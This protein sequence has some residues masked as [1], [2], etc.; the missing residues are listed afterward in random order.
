MNRRRLLQLLSA[1]G[2]GIALSHQ[3]GLIGDALAA[4]PS[5]P[6]VKMR[7]GMA[8]YAG[9]TWPIVAVR[10]GWF[11]EVGIELDPP[12][13]RIYFEN[14]L[15]PLFQNKEMD[16]AIAYMGSLTPIIDRVKDIKPFMI[17]LWWRGN[18]IFTAPD[19]EFKTVDDFIEEG[20]PFNEAAMLTMA[21][22]KG[23][24]I[25]VPP[26]VSSRA[27]L[28]YVYGLGGMKLEDSELVA[29]EDPNA[30]QLAVSGGVDF[31]APLGGVQIYQM[32]Q[33]AKWRPLISTRQLVKYAN[34]EGGPSVQGIL[35]Y[36]GVCATTDYIANNR[37]TIHR[38]NSV[39]YRTVAA[40]LGP[41]QMTEIEKMVPFTNSVTGASLDAQSIKFIFEELDP[42]FVYEAQETIWY[43]TSSPLYYR[44]IYEGQIA[45]FIKDGVIAEGDYDLDDF[46]VAKKFYDEAKGMKA[47]ADE[48]IKST[49]AANLTG[50]KKALAEAGKAWYA[51]YNFLDAVRFLESAAA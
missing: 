40:V 11:D 2:A 45:Q 10:N 32:Q 35:N 44:N 6:K 17:T 26:N 49:D 31:C 48:L 37:D 19:S 23:R 7:F 14:Q 46:F 1:T 22:L 43:D 25:T 15:V 28:N 5:I 42:L 29:L 12:D 36:D 51:K 41:D 38:M 33:Q 9:Q 47:K 30:V 50:E 8:G 13:G 18:A 21:Q 4:A 20:K 3:F 34:L 24:K 39:M 16:V 27:W